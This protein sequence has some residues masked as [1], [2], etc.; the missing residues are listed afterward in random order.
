MNANGIEG[1]GRQSSPVQNGGGCLMAN[2]GGHKPNTRCGQG[3]PGCAPAAAR[4]RAR[5]PSPA[6]AGL[7]TARRRRRTWPGS[8]ER[9]LETQAG[10][11]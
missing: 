1:G 7:G 11:H 9:C 5:A 4:A 8:S 2:K 6:R 10:K 3:A